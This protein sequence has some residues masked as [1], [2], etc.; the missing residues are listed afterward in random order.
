MQIATSLSSDNS[1]VQRLWFVGSFVLFACWIIMYMLLHT[2]NNEVLCAWRVACCGEREAETG[3]F[4]VR[5]SD[6]YWQ[7]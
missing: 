4:D 5:D 2:G 1:L 7:E 6:V 3:V